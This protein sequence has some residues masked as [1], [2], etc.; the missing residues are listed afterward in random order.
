MNATALLS[1]MFDRW[2]RR[3]I[4]RQLLLGQVRLAGQRID[5]VPPLPT[6]SG[7]LHECDRVSRS[8]PANL[9]GR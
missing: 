8:G 3:Q 5:A 2:Y 6:R 4:A 9:G 7:P 1:R